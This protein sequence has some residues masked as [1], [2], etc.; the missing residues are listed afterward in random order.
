MT[1]ADPLLPLAEREV[2]ERIDEITA[3]AVAKDVERLDAFHLFGPNYTKF[4]DWRPLERQDAETARRLEREAIGE[5]VDLSADVEELK[6]DV[7]GETAVATFVF[8]YSF[9]NGHDRVAV[10]A[11]STLV[12]V[13]DGDR[14]W[15]IVHEHFSP[16][17]AQDD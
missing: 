8:A 13:R 2:A 6:V 3:A 4:D 17:R 10:R 7:F 11:R 1:L 12:F 5:A 14:G 15:L 9:S 16:F